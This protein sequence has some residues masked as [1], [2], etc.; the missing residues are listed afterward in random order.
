[1]KVLAA[2][3][4]ML[5]ALL[6]AAAIPAAQAQTADPAI[7]TVQGFYDAL[8]GSMKAGKAAGGQGRYARMRPAVEKAFDANTMI[9]Y[10]VGPGWDSAGPA[11]QKALTEAFIRMTASQYAGNFDSFNG[12]KF[13]VDPKVTIRGTDHYVSSKLVTKDQTVAFIYRVRQFGSDWKII[14]VLLDGSISQLSVYRNDFAA[15]M[16]SGGPSALVK[17]IDELSAKALK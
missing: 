12:E 1:M 2:A 6:F 15:T 16:K 10:A 4:S 17:K 11:D 14:D 9:K 3:F 7:A 13:V 8:L 5:F